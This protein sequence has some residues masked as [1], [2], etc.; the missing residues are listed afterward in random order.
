[1]G[2]QKKALLI[3]NDIYYHP[4]V[5]NLS[6]CI[7]DVEAIESQLSRNVDGTANFYTAL[8]RN[9][10]NKRMKEEIAFFLKRPAEQAVIY[11]SGHG[12]VSQEGGFL[13]GKDAEKGNIGVSTKWLSD[14]VKESN[15]TD[16]T[17]I[18]DCCHAAEL[19]SKMELEGNLSVL[20]KGVSLLAATNR[21]DVAIEHNSRGVFSVIIEQGLNGAGADIFGNV[22]AADLFALAQNRLSPF[23]QRPVFKSVTDSLKPLRKCEPYVNIGVIRKLIT[24][25]F[26]PKVD[27]EIKVN[28][29]ILNQKKAE[30]DITYDTYLTLFIYEKAGLIT[31][32][33]THSL[34]QETFEWGSCTLSAYGQH[35]WDLIHK[36]RI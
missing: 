5:K 25:E 14:L 20:P 34:I 30:H 3:G 36:K 6:G 8:H 7:N 4:K 32:E 10:T 9:L 13:C 26:F 18:L 17:I 11:F 27:S 16:L 12:Y 31:C 19:F 28:P 23:Q 24:D 33:K 15:I 35:V 2:I 22:N 1:M 29:D 21:D